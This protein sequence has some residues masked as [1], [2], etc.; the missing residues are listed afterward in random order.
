[1][2]S[3]DIDTAIAELDK[4]LEENQ[5]DADPIDEGLLNAAPTQLFPNHIN[6]TDEFSIVEGALAGIGVSVSDNNFYFVD[7]T[8][9][10]KLVKAYRYEGDIWNVTRSPEDDFTLP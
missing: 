10:P 9:D 3:V 7:I 1:M 2:K 6:R 5:I 4:A 8:S